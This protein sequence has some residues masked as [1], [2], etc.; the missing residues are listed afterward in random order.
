[1]ELVY[2][3][4]PHGLCYCELPP[5]KGDQ[6]P[7]DYLINDL[8]PEFRL[9]LRAGGRLLQKEGKELLES[10][11]M[12]GWRG[13]LYIMGMDF[14]V[15]EPQRQYEAIGIGQEYALGALHILEKV[16]CTTRQ[17]IKAAMDAASAHSKGCAPPY[18]IYSV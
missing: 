12:I 8:F 2:Q 10:E 5:V 15:M 11:M 9:K 17:K 13:S 14:S 7:Y 3:P 6:D 16:E 4:I 1:M 18:T